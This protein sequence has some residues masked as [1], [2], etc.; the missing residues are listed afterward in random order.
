MV[1]QS[2]LG[3]TSIV[4][5]FTSFMACDLVLSFETGAI[6]RSQYTRTYVVLLCLHLIGI[7]GHD[8]SGIDERLLRW[9]VFAMPL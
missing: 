6:D 5:I 9:A 2:L 4:H 8:T 3:K 1:D 7:V